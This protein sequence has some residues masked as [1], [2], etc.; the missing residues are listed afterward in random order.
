MWQSETILISSHNA[1]YIRKESVKPSKSLPIFK[2]KPK[3]KP[4]AGCDV[5]WYPEKLLIRLEL[6][7]NL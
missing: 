5:L 1:C 6:F 4:Y 3:P 7:D 2:P